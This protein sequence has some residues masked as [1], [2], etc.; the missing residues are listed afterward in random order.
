MKGMLAGALAH[1]LLDGVHDGAHLTTVRRRH[2]HE[3]V[4][5]PHQLAYILNYDVGRLLRVGC[6]SRQQ[7]GLPRRDGALLELLAC[8][9]FDLIA[10]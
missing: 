6:P 8:C 3:V 4:R 2:D 1:G 7:G 10:H 5:N 9:A